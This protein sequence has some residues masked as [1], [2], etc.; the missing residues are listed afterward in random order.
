MQNTGHRSGSGCPPEDRMEAEGLPG[1][2]SADKAKE[3]ERG[4][5]GNSLIVQVARKSSLLAAYKK[6][7]ANR[8]APGID[9]MTV[10]AARGYLNE[11][12]REIA[13]S[14]I[15]GTYKPQP[16][17]RVNIPK[18]DG[19]TRALGIPCVVDRVVAQSLAQALEPIFEP[20]FSDSSYGF[21]PGRSAHQAISKAKE[22]VQEGYTRVVDIDL[23]KYFDTINHD[24][25][26]DMVMDKVKD[27]KAIKLIRAFLKG[28]AMEGGLLSETD[29]GSPQ[30]SP[31]SPILS[32]VYLTRFDQWLEARGHRFVRY[33]DDC[34]IYLKSQRAAERVM[35][36]SVEFLEGKRMKLTVN[37]EKSQ[38]GSPFRLK[39]LGFSMY[40]LNGKAAIRIH[41]KTI[42]RLKQKIRAITKRNR[43]RSFDAIAAE[44][45]QYTD[46]WLNYYGIADSRSVIGMINKWIRRRLRMYIWKQWKTV[47]KRHKS[48]LA[49]GATKQEAWKWANTSKSY[50]RT[51][52]SQ[53]LQ[54]T[55]T[56]EILERRGYSDML[57]KY[58]SV[59]LKF[60]TA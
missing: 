18:P 26:M 56:N 7:R 19:G 11:H 36:N 22:Y 27:R 16:V 12:W 48:L 29:E 45:K 51:S 5:A 57:K 60:R 1:A 37:R 55:I 2:Q 21:R 30:G 23:A 4:G 10:D 53:I 9:G 49:L 24:I 58:D 52:G 17:R 13:E 40:R 14:L 34:N 15:N 28:G 3:E 25:L 43:G 35:A 39:F 32:N 50:W 59:H 54:T 47:K 41:A 42:N 33:A 44:L 6:V 46:G 38:I 8:G 31:L 20:G